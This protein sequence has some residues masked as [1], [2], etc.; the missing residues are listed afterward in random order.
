MNQF[1]DALGVL[2]HKIS[3]ETKKDM[4]KADDESKEKLRKFFKILDNST[5]DDEMV[6]EI[7]NFLGRGSLAIREVE[8]HGGQRRDI[9]ASHLGKSRKEYESFLEGK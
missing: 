1:K 6:L 7:K 8:F 4:D 9:V 5:I 2:D 3:K